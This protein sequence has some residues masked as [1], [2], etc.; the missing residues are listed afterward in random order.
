MADQHQ[1]IIETLTEWSKL[2]VRD[3]SQNTSDFAQSDDE[4]RIFNIVTANRGKAQRLP[5]K[6][7][8]P[9]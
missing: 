8:L 6:I 5:A 1:S 9:V 4:K 2:N 3:S 7:L